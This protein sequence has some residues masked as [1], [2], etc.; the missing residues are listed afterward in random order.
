[1][2]K[3]LKKN[4]TALILMSVIND[5]QTHVKDTSLHKYF[6]FGWRECN[7]E[8]SSCCICSWAGIGQGYGGSNENMQH[9]FMVIKDDLLERY[10]FFV[11]T[12]QVYI[13]IYKC[14][15]KKLKKVVIASVVPT[16]LLLWK[17]TRIYLLMKCCNYES[18]RWSNTLQRAN[19]GLTHLDSTC[20]KHRAIL[21]V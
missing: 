20:F 17:T 8:K 18:H 1:M 16:Y 15:T 6:Q 3:I 19:R 13:Y 2:V 5:E 12:L 10:C 11:R 7:Q 21:C 14:M 4:P 9:S